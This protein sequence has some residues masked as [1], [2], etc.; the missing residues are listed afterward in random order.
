MAS[1]GTAPRLNQCTDSGRIIVFF[2]GGESLVRAK[3]IRC[4]VFATD[5]IC[6]K[7]HRVIKCPKESPKKQKQ[8][9]CRSTSLK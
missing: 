1:G 8:L 6:L 7:H 9:N 3:V 5:Y 2:W 4:G